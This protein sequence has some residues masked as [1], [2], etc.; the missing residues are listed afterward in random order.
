MQ[1]GNDPSTHG[2][3]GAGSAADDGDVTVAEAVDD[4]VADAGLVDV[5]EVARLVEVPVA[6]VVADGAA[7]PV[8]AGAAVEVGAVVIG[9]ASRLAQDAPS[10][11]TALTPAATRGVVRAM[12]GR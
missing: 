1:S 2:E 6:P 11:S 4:E 3:P 12:P 7:V 5:V 8:V 9:G 10:R